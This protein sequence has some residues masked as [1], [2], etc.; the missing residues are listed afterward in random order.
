LKLT[1]IG[2]RTGQERNTVLGYFDDP[3]APRAMVIVASAGGSARHPDW[4]FNLAK[5]PDQ[6]WVQVGD[7]RDHAR[8]ELLTGAERAA[9]SERSVAEAPRYGS[10]QSKTAREIPP[11]RLT[12]A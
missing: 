9:A 4:Y 1:T 2:A 8:P 12:R 10:Y 3:D 6:V 11:V 7:R 5:H